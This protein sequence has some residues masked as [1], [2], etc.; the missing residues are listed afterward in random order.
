MEG[1]KVEGVKGTP[2]WKRGICGA[3]EERKE[4]E[5]ADGEDNAEE[6]ETEE[7]TLRLELVAKEYSLRR[8]ELADRTYLE[9][10]EA[11]AAREAFRDS[12]SHASG[13]A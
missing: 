12:S 3:K 4:E 2:R 5:P 6:T 11:T 8:R 7:E 1:S 13:E 9:S 10:P